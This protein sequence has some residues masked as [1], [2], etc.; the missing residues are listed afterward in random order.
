[1]ILVLS[2]SECGTWSLALREGHRLKRKINMNCLQKEINVESGKW[3]RKER[4]WK[5]GER[6]KDKKKKKRGMTREKARKKGRQCEEGKN[7]IK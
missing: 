1:M 2:L 7:R 4:K 5:R 6:S 3:T